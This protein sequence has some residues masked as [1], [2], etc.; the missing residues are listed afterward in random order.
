MKKPAIPSISS[1]VDKL[2][3]AISTLK[4]GKSLPDPAPLPD[5]E[6]TPEQ[7]L[8]DGI[9][10]YFLASVRDN[11]RQVGSNRCGHVSGLID[12]VRWPPSWKV[13]EIARAGMRLAIAALT[14]LH[15]ID[16]S[17]YRRWENGEGEVIFLGSFWPKLNKVTQE[18]SN[19]YERALQDDWDRRQREREKK[20][21]RRRHPSR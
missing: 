4:K 19:V 10:N 12:D 1:L 7:Y 15:G 2:L 18:H 17:I 5:G 3:A 13:E 14:D 20:D 8:E 11:L 6:F 16:S 9:K 21:E